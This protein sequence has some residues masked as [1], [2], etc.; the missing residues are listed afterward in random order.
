MAID[1]DSCVEEGG[2]SITPFM[3]QKINPTRST[4][5]LII[6]DSAFYKST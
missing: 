3:L 1:F 6:I 5:V 4:Y 2:P